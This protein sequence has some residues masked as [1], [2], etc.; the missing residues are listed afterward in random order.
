[1]RPRPEPLEPERTC[2]PI[3]VAAARLTAAPVPSATEQERS[4]PASAAADHSPP[5]PATIIQQP[6]PGL[7][8]QSSERHSEAHR[9]APTRQEETPVNTTPSFEVPGAMRDL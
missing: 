8:D 4:R 7:R 6:G 3:V 5:V 1:M 2:V 9:R